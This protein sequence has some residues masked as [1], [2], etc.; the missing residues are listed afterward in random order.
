MA[1]K[2]LSILQ[3]IVDKKVGEDM[4]VYRK[5]T[6]EISKMEFFFSRENINV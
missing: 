4:K 3:K 6:T 5:S 2:R 1:L